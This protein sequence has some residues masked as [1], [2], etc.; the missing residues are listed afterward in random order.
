MFEQYKSKINFENKVLSYIKKDWDSK[1]KNAKELE[2]FKG[3]PFK[4]EE[5]RQ[6]SYMKVVL[7]VGDLFRGLENYVP[8]PRLDQFDPR[9]E[10][11]LK[12]WESEGEL[13][14]HL[15]VISYALFEKYGV[16]NDK[17]MKLVQGY[18][19]HE[20][21]KDNP[22]A[23]ALA[24]IHVGIHSWLSVKGRVVDLT[25]GQEKMFFDFKGQEVIMGEVPEG[26][27][28][29][30]F[31]EPKKVVQKHLKRY[32]DFLGMTPEEYIQFH[33]KEATRFVN[34]L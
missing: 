17:E 24:N 5:L 12:K 19:W 16:F 33:H 15:T 13:C 1:V 9:I 3:K 25:I 22:L 11:E 28:L 32:A 6:P 21:R 30:G 2:T 27:L 34:N 18:F 14:L 26:M 10:Q 31:E 8:S 29:K 20:A 4:T 23:M 7:Y